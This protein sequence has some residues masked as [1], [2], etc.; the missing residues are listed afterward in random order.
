MLHGR[1]HRGDKSP[2][3]LP[4][5]GLFHRF[6]DRPAQP[7]PPMLRRDGRRERGN[8][9]GLAAPA[10]VYEACFEY[11]IQPSRQVFSRTVPHER[12]RVARR[13]YLSPLADCY[14]EAG[15]FRR[16]PRPEPV[17]D[18]VVVHKLGPHGRGDLTGAGLE[19]RPLL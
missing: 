1:P 5:C 16:E 12:Y 18:R 7:P 17:N 3:A 19:F 13:Q 2:D 15:E 10:L 4:A 6:K 8:G 11:R 14:L 9:G